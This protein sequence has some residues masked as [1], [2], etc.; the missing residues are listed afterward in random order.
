M[1]KLGLEI[2]F[3]RVAKAMNFEIRWLCRLTCVPQKDTFHFLTPRTFECVFYLETGFFANTVKM[4]S[5]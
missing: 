3:S 5:Q 4:K 1:R 2:F